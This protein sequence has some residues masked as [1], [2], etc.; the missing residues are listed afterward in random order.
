MY[1]IFK[2]LMQAQVQVLIQQLKNFLKMLLQFLWFMISKKKNHLKEMKNTL[3]DVNENYKDVFKA[4]IV[5]SAD[6][7]ENG[8]KIEIEMEEFS[9][10]CDS[11]LYLKKNKKGFNDLYKLFL[12]I[13]KNVPKKDEDAKQ[14]IKEGKGCCNCSIF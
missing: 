12:E 7:K 2:Y 5:K 13:A 10:K 14:E 4:L 6:Y 3:N 11:T 8:K 1:L 9:K